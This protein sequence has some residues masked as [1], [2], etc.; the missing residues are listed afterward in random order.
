[1]TQRGTTGLVVTT[2]TEREI[3]IARNFDAPR[4]LVFDAWTKCEHLK[5]WFGRRGDE[6]TVCEIDLR[7]GGAWRLVS[8]LREGGEMGQQGEYQEIERPS[9]LVQTE[10]FE[11]PDFE[12]MGSGTLNTL[13]FE[14]SSGT[15][16]MT[17][18]VLYDSKE[19]RDGALKT[20]MEEG[21]RETFDKLA[22]LV[23]TL[24]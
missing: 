20:P 6:V 2:P 9:R 4:T 1:M 22:E 3:R 14:E 19:A 15:T 16:T 24:R 8:R 13:L 5:R 21:M 10:L 23:A 18:T 17:V 11:G 12:P 7:P